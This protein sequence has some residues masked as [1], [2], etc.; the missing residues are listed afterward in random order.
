MIIFNKH[1]L[2][3]L[4]VV[5]MSEGLISIKI[6]NVHPVEL[7]KFTLSLSKFADEYKYF[8]KKKEIPSKQEE[9]VLYVKEVK[10]GSIEVILT[11]AASLLPVIEYTN[12]FMDFGS[13]LIRIIN[14][15]LGK[16]ER[17]TDID[18]KDCINIRDINE[19]IA[20]NSGS[21]INIK[22]GDIT[23][24]ALFLNI[25]SQEANAIQNQV[26]KE[27][28]KL[29]EPDG[30]ERKEVVLYW[31]QVKKGEGVK[32]GTTGDKA[33]IEAISPHPLS[34]YF[35]ENVS[36][37]KKRM[38][39]EKSNPLK[40]AYIVDVEI[41]SVKGKPIAYKITNIHEELDIGN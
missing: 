18:Q 24:S 36:W 22:F 7:N 10:T 5:D 12:L 8:C 21:N 25:N 9:V 29:A 6:N 37:I 2:K 39:E 11:A 23:N 19:V 13:Y 20:N 40:T 33:I 34:V 32:K 30:K 3:P 31:K 15:L 26:A 14:Y 1:I 28:E 38:T 4:K 41:L 35:P 17:P 16:S 27:L